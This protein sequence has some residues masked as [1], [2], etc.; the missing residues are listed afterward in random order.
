MLRFEAFFRKG[1]DGLIKFAKVHTFEIN[2][3]FTEYPY[4]IRDERHF[5][6]ERLN[7]IKF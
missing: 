3:N 5:S 4:S 7:S 6:K 1:E 2:E